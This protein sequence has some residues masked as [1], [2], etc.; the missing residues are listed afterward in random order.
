MKERRLKNIPVTDAASV[1]IS[2]LNA[3]DALQALLTEVE[4]EK[5]CCAITECASATIEK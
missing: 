2:I 3:R 4:H 1:P 5:H